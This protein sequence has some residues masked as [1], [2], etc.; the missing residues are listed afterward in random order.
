ML[1]QGE[2]NIFSP[3]R[4]FIYYNEREMEGTVGTDAGAQIRD[5][6]KSIGKQGVV[7]ETEWPYDISKF[8]DK[9]GSALYTEAKH[10]T[11][12]RYTRVIQ[13]IVHIKQAIAE[14]FPVVFGFSVYESFESPEVAKTGIMP[15]PKKDEHLMGGHAVMVVGFDDSRKCVIV[16]NSWGESWGDKGYF[17]MPYAFIENSDLANDFWIVYKVMDVN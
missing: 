1:K 8:T 16:R 11:A 9:P 14:G 13:D 12:I 4:L 6:I 15:M 5:G 10:H 7:S 2:E 17:Y 3:S